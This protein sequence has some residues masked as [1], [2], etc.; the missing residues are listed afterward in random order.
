MTDKASRSDEIFNVLKARIIRWD[1]PPAHRLTEDAL[2]AEFGVS[3]IPVREALH[4]LVENNLVDRVPHRGCTVKQPN[5]GEIHELYEVRLALELYVVEQ[6]ALQGLGQTT[7]T[8]LAAQWQELAGHAAAA[9]LPDTETLARHDEAFHET[10]A[11]ATGNVTLLAHLRLLNERLLFM[12]MTDIT[13]PNTLRTSAISS[14]LN[15][16]ST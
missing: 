12:R 10:L 13:T 5:L 8:S 3:R 15:P 4:M 6:L 11:A 9:E 14:L 1:Y 2:C 16:R 7:H